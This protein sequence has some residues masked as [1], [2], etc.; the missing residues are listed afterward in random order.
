MNR[1]PWQS[2]PS[3]TNLATGY[4]SKNANTNS[5][6]NL[7]QNTYNNNNNYYANNQ[8]KSQKHNNYRNNHT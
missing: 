2:N 5:F 6:P 4:N 1:F 7:H 8:A 3:N